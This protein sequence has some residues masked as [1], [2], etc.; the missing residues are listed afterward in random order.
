[1]LHFYMSVVR[2]V[3]EYASPVWHSSLTKEQSD[4]IEA[5]QKRAFCIIYNSSGIDYDQFCLYHK[6]QKLYDR[7]NDIS[8]HFFVHSV[9]V[10]SSCLHYLLPQ[11]RDMNVTSK[12]R[13]CDSFIQTNSPTTR[14]RK[15]FLEFSITNYQ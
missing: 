2:P 13:H 8:R 15:S 6:L 7:R 3:L 11:E 4:R 9:L 14:F 1:M 5:I 10:P 12:L